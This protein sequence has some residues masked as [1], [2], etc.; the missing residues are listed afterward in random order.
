LSQGRSEFVGSDVLPARELIFIILVA[1]AIRLSWAATISVAPLSDSH[2][3]D[4][5]ARNLLHYGVFGW[6]S[7]TPFA[8]WPPG[9]SFLYA[10]VYR[11]FGES[12]SNIVGLNIL[13]SCGLLAATARVACRFYGGQVATVATGILAIWPTLIMFTTVLASELPFML[14]T[15]GALDAWSMPRRSLLLRSIIAGGLLGAAALVRPLAL[16]LP[17]LFGVSLCFS[18][19]FSLKV[20]GTEFRMVFVSSIIMALVISPWTWRNYKLYGE[21]VLISTNGGIT[22]WMGNSPG[23]D[24]GYMEIPDR[25]S[26]LNDNEQSKILGEEARDYIRDYPAAFASRTLKK[27]LQLYSNESIGVSWNLRGINDSFGDHA[28]L[29]FKR[30]TQISWALIFLLAFAGL[31]IVVSSYGWRAMISPVV[32]CIIFYTLVCG[33]IVS[34]DRYHLAFAPQLAILAA[35]GLLSF[36][37]RFLVHRMPS[38]PASL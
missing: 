4:I 23:T 9:T 21:P 8:F 26:Q 15:I 18:G 24:G 13:L 20:L 30:L 38:S 22:F 10:G 5:F 2:A 33:I 36:R 3:Y 31:V 6:T 29:F 7:D 27:V 17:L 16:A 28:I 32:I 1:L 37:K 34:Q 35:V 11:V 14:F 25:L 19:P 12:F